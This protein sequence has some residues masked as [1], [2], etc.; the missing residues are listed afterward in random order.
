MK[1]DENNDI[2]EFGEG[3]LIGLK[4]KSTL[5]DRNFEVDSFEM[6]PPKDGEV[7]VFVN[8][9]YQYGKDKNYNQGW[10]K[11]EFSSDGIEAILKNVVIGKVKNGGGNVFADEAESSSESIHSLDYNY[12]YPSEFSKKLIQLVDEEAKNKIESYVPSD[13]EELVGGISDGMT[14][15]DIAKMHNISYTSLRKQAEIGYG[16]EAE[17]TS[18]RK[19]IEEITKDHLFENP[20]YYTMLSEMENKYEKIKS[21]AH[22]PFKLA[23]Y[24]KGESVKMFDDEPSLIVMEI[25]E[26]ADKSP[27]Y[28]LK[29]EDGS[30]VRNNIPEDKIHKM[31]DIQQGAE[32]PELPVHV[33][34][35]VVS[36]EDTLS[37]AIQDVIENHPTKKYSNLDLGEA[38]IL[39]SLDEKDLNEDDSWSLGDPETLKHSVY[40]SLYDKGYIELSDEEVDLN[41]AHDVQSEILS[42]AYNLSNEGKQF[43]NAVN[44][45][46]ETLKSVSEGT[47][48]FPAE[49]AIPENVPEKNY[50]DIKS[51]LISEGDNE[52]IYLFEGKEI[53]D[54]STA[55]IERWKIVSFFKYGVNLEHVEKNKLATKK[56]SKQLTFTDILSLYDNGEI[57]IDGV[58][59]HTTL[60]HCLKLLVKCID[61]I[62]ARDGIEQEKS[63]HA[64]T[65]SEQ[66]LIKAAHEL[67]KAD[68]EAKF[69][70]REGVLKK[71]KEK[72]K[73]HQS[74]KISKI[75]YKTSQ[76][77]I[78]NSLIELHDSVMKSFR[79][80]KD[81]D[82]LVTKDRQIAYKNAMDSGIAAM[83]LEFPLSEIVN[84]T[85]STN[86][87]ILNLYLSLSGLYGGQDKADAVKFLSNLSSGRAKFLYGGLYSDLLFEEEGTPKQIE[88][89]LEIKRLKNIKESRTNQAE[90]D[91]LDEAIEILTMLLDDSI[92]NEEN[93]IAVHESKDGYW[94]IASKPTT[95]AIALEHISGAP[96]GQVGKVVK[97][98]EARA[99]KKVVGEEY[100]YE[101]GGE[102]GGRGWGEF[103]KGRR[104]TDIKD[105][106]IGKMYLSHNNKF[107][108]DNIFIINRGD[109]TGLDRDIV[110]ASFVRPNS[111][112]HKEGDFALWGD[113]LQ[114]NELYEIKGD[115]YA[116]GG[117]ILKEIST[118][119]AVKDVD[120]INI[121]EK[122]LPISIAE[123][124][125]LERHPEWFKDRLVR[126]IPLDN[127]DDLFAMFEMYEEDNPINLAE[128]NDEF[129]SMGDGGSVGLTPEDMKSG[130]SVKHV[131][132]PQVFTVIEKKDD[133]TWELESDGFNTSIGEK[134]LRH[135]RFV[136]EERKRNEIEYAKGGGVGERTYSQWE[137]E[138]IS[139]VESELDVTRSD[140]Q[141]VVEAQSFKMA[142]SWGK[143]LSGKETAKI[144]ILESEKM[145]DGGA[146]GFIPM[147]L[148]EIIVNTAK[149]GDTDMKGVIGILSAMIDSGLTDDDLKTPPTKTGNQYT[150]AKDKKTKE[151]WA[152]IEPNYKGELKGYWAVTITGNYRIVFQFE[153]GNVYLLDYVDYH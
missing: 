79:F 103:H 104:I 12:D 122:G 140:A 102:V 68:L 23:D 25:N 64:G 50:S 132:L 96:S 142:Q 100:L 106:K 20:Y 26:W 125:E 131:S 76:K 144:I 66:E 136:P 123:G 148:E 18:D 118:H 134:N 150:N 37:I 24:S 41:S 67:E 14:L 28:D 19:K 13:N 9:K 109:E 59:S 40:N 99:H 88:W 138:V 52:S 70:E 129:S 152:I 69:K 3:G 30:I 124:D 147:D 146:I 74:E 95:K 53:S 90:I 48:M 117:V 143:G 35:T 115:I 56:E 21:G 120:V 114:D 42:L 33:A 1:N 145:K 17:H 84:K 31:E 36:D 5:K 85:L 82:L 130:I 119:K 113:D 111:L 73:K 151:I 62:D 57:T 58:D 83:S 153:D 8:V 38:K 139:E 39:Y 91:T 87:P 15:E 78:A 51:C 110:Y 81:S 61:L 101:K 72:L 121:Y 16:I 63:L 135:W 10:H 97:L 108:S 60:N 141:G 80:N 65:K 71:T 105:L 49:A 112:K 27:T 137:D 44:A 98:D 116:D 128:G 92:V 6:L 55:I 94:S 86:N 133:G 93:Y 2:I 4:S 29:S 43:I 47:D 75:N 45:R 7:I 127:E 34:E 107:N 11:L 126:S 32:L 89:K 22:E 77:N 54:T 149:W 46:I